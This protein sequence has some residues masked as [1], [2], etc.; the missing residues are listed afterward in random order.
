[1]APCS[2]SSRGARAASN[3][4]SR[5]TASFDRGVPWGCAALSCTT[6]HA[7]STAAMMGRQ[8]VRSTQVRRCG[9]ALPAHAAAPPPQHASPPPIAPHTRTRKLGEELLQPRHHLARQGAGVLVRCKV[10]Q[11]RQPWRGAVPPGLDGQR[12]QHGMQVWPW[13]GVL[14]RLPRVRGV[15]QQRRMHG[16]D[17]GVATP[18]PVKGH[19]GRVPGRRRRD[20][21][22][23]ADLLLAPAALHMAPVRDAGAYVH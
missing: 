23:P 7:C 20:E 18:P 4:M 21:R 11:H 1:M 19:G 10:C 13:L 5:C 3:R 8:G 12:K 16:N 17:H 2:A 14:H 22:P 15:Q 6:I 9:A